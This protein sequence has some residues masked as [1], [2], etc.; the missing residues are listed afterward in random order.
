MKIISVI[1]ALFVCIFTSVAFAADFPD[2]SA[3]QLKTRLDGGEKLILINTLPPLLHQT[4][5]LPGSLNIPARHVKA[6]LPEAV[7][8]KGA[9]LVFYCMGPK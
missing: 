2:I 8:D 9:P 4:K 6:K 3:Q 1:S 7:A 5:H